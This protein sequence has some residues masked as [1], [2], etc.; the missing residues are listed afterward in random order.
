[1]ADIVDRFS[2]PGDTILDPFC[3]AGT[4]CVAA[5][6]LGRKSIGFETD[7]TTAKIAIRRINDCCTHKSE[8]IP[9]IAEKSLA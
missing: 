6:K 4:T 1:M 9:E 7:E 3:G 2:Q 5:Q 8:P